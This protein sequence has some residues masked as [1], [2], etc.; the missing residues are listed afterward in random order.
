MVDMDISHCILYPRYVTFSLD[1]RN[2]KDFFTLKKLPILRILPDM[3]RKFDY[4][5]DTLD[6]KS[7]DIHMV[8]VYMDI[9]LYILPS[10]NCK[11]VIR[12]SKFEKKK[13]VLK[14]V[15]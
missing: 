15:L 6:Y 3:H 2:L 1:F 11:F 7:W 10:E 4:W 14:F 13:S 8:L 5:I 12:F 9:Y